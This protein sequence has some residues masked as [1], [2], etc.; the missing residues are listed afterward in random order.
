MKDAHGLEVIQNSWHAKCPD[1][2]RGVRLPLLSVAR[3]CGNPVHG[4]KRVKVIRTPSELP[5]D[6]DQE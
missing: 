1:C 2:G 4:S 3:Y 6:H 5:P